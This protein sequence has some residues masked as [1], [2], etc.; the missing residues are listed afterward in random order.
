MGG[1]LALEH[2]GGGILGSACREHHGHTGPAT[3]TDRG[4]SGFAI[5]RSAVLAADCGIQDIKPM[6]NNNTS[7]ITTMPNPMT[8]DDKPNAYIKPRRLHQR[9]RCHIPLNS[10]DT[11]GQRW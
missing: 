7:P 8:T 10:G 3:S 11:A 4:G 9:V 1:A 6:I 2:P 5:R